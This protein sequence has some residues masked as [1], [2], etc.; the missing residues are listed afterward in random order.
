MKKLV[1]GDAENDACVVIGDHL[2]MELEIKLEFALID[3]ALK[4]RIIRELKLNMH[5]KQQ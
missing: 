5:L 1:E 3:F 2:K 4:F